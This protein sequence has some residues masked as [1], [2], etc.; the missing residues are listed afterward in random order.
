MLFMATY[1]WL[2]IKPMK[3]NFDISAVVLLHLMNHFLNLPAEVNG[4]PDP[5]NRLR[6]HQ[7]QITDSFEIQIHVYNYGRG[8][9]LYSFL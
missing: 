2:P 5:S 6:C 9:H 8:F 4:Y 3:L 7:K 1:Q